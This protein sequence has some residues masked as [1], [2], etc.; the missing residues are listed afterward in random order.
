M[1]DQGLSGEDGMT[2]A[3]HFNLPCVGED[4]VIDKA[5]DVSELVFLV[6]TANLVFEFIICIKM[7]FKGTL[8]TSRDDGN[9]VYAGV[10]CFLDTILDQWLVEDRQDLFGHGFGCGQKT[11]TVARCGEKAFPDH[12]QSSR[13][14]PMPG[15]IVAIHSC[16]TVDRAR[17]VPHCSISC[18][19]NK[20]LRIDD[21]R[22]ILAQGFMH[23]Y[24][25]IM[26]RHLAGPGQCIQL[27]SH[28]AQ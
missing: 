26:H 20:L 16:D 6:T 19:I 25:A 15:H 21:K 1:T 24:G 22:R 14:G 3:T 11:R 27:K 5:T 8:A 18:F 4:A 9:L 13:P 10:N 12:V 17:A 7:I 28:A 23:R 2:E